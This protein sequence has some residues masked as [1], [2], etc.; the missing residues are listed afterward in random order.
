MSETLTI[1]IGTDTAYARINN[2]HIVEVAKLRLA[3]QA[4]LSAQQKL[5][6]NRTLDIRFPRF[7]SFLRA[8][9]NS[10]VNRIVFEDVQ[11]LGSQY[12]TQLWG[13][14]RGAIWAAVC[15]CK[16]PGVQIYI[17]PSTLL[18]YF[19]T[20][21]VNSHK[22]DMAKA[23]ALADPEKYQLDSSMELY[24]AG[25]KINDDEIDAIW[26]ARFTLA[27]DRGEQKFR[28]VPNTIAIARK[29]C[30]NREVRKQKTIIT[31]Y[32]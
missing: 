18:K 11:F 29:K 26:L 30:V 1:D 21:K 9:L 6:K 2:G 12:A 7:L 14:L 15:E 4:E 22:I 25:N 23:L 13:S 10:S 31:S 20:G 28:L 27:V 32:L 3:T 5:G 16:S 17:V 19:A 24:R 8:Q